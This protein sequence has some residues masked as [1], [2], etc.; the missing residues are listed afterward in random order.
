MLGFLKVILES[1]SK[2]VVQLIMQV[3]ITVEANYSLVAK[4]KE[5]LD[6]EWKIKVQYVYRE[7][8]HATDW[9]A[10]FS[11]SMNSLDRSN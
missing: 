4:P 8:N 11:L 10:N 3:S 6:R 9:L 1:E 2:L 7:A 5:L